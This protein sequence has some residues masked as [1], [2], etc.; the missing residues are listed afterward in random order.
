[1]TRAE[2]RTDAPD[3][4]DRNAPR[5]HRARPEQSGRVALWLFVAFLAVAAWALL[6]HLGRYFW[7]NG[8]EWDFLASR[9]AGNLGDLFRAH[10]EHPSFLPVL[11]YRAMWQLFGLRSYRPYQVPVIA[12]HLTAAGLLRVVMRRAGV[13]PWIATAA[14]A[15]FVL[16]G[17][18][19]E[20]IIW[21]FQIGFT[22]SLVFGLSHLLLADH[23]GPFGRRD[24]LAVSVGSCGLLCSGLAPMYAAVV[25]IVVFVKRGWRAATFHAA[26]IFVAYLAW[27]VFIGVDR[28]P[29][30]YHRP[31]DVLAI[32]HFVE[33]GEIATFLGL[34]GGNHVVAALLAVALFGGLGLAWFSRPARDRL[35]LLIVPIALLLGGALFL[36]VSGYGR[37]WISPS[38][39]ESSRYVHLV[40]AFTLPALAVAFDALARRWKAVG[41]VAAIVLVSGVP[42]NIGQ[43]DTLFP[44][45]GAYF[46]ARRELVAAMARSPYIHEVPL[47]TRPD[48]FWST[49][50]DKWLLDALHSGRLPDVKNPADID[51]PTFRLRFGLAVIKAPAPGKCGVIRKPVVVSLRKGDELGV[52][53]GPWTRAKSGWF[54]TQSYTVQLVQNGKPVGQTLLEYPGDGN[55]L[56]AQLDG[57]DVRFALAPGTESLI[58]CR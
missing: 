41:A 52:E 50:D 1:M 32:L 28:I 31:T 40:A 34:G 30:P 15:S 10:N 36:L 19:E 46:A 56:R 12:L 44:F 7:F 18:G 25:G 39:G 23:D 8:D 58:L 11:V 42:H 5:D 6:F 48:P 3:G 43:F 26:P 13:N 29:D 24:W 35:R 57:L 49:F 22:G 37:W 21:A 33:M 51:D 38:V 4:D 2:V 9:T 45:D 27:V 17:P 20:N 16:F 53:V 54:F 14:A 47:A 55:L